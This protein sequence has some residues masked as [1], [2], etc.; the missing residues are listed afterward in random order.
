MYTA[1]ELFGSNRQKTVTK[2]TKQ[3]D[4]YSFGIIFY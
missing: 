3:A 2:P 1:P 4:V